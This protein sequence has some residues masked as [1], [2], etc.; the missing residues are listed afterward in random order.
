MLIYEDIEFFFY[1]VRDN[2]FMFQIRNYNAF[3]TCLLLSKISVALSVL[4]FKTRKQKLIR[5]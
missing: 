4:S 1:I 2:D 3:Q 5:E